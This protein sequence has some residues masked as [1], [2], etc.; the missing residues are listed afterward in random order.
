MPDGRTYTSHDRLVFAELSNR[1]SQT[2]QIVAAA[3]AMTTSSSANTG[4]A[5]TPSRSTATSGMPEERTC[6]TPDTVDTFPSA[7]RRLFPHPGG[8]QLDWGSVDTPPEEPRG[9]W[10]SY[11]P[12]AQQSRLGTGP[13]RTSMG[14]RSI[15][16]GE[17]VALNAQGA[18][19]M[20]AGLLVRHRK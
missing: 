9:G 13:E 14:A 1:G 6:S 18:P 10:A 12:F 7:R 17:P 19:G 4:L 3:S 16:T 5:S 8:F 2:N 20:A 15:L 11:A